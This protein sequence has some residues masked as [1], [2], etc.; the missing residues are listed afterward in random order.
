M[1]QLVNQTT[2]YAV[3]QSPG[4]GSEQAWSQASGFAHTQVTN[5][6]KRAAI[7]V[8]LLWNDAPGFRDQEHNQ[9]NQAE[10]H[11]LWKPAPHVKSH[12]WLGWMDA[13]WGLPGSLNAETAATN[14]T[15]A[16]GESYDA[17]VQRERTWLAWSRE[18]SEANQK[19]GIWAYGQISNKH[20]PFGTSP[21]FNGVKDESEQFLSLRWWNAR[22]KAWGDR[23]KITVDQSVIARY[24]SLDLLERDN[25]YAENSLRY[26]IDS[27]TASHWASV[28]SRLEWDDHW[29]LDVQLAIEHMHRRSEGERRIYADSTGEY[30][31]SYRVLDPLPF[32]QLAYQWNPEWRLFAQYGNGGSHPTSFELVD[33]EGFQPYELQPEEAN[34]IEL[35]TR[36]NHTA[37]SGRWQ[38]TLQAFH[39][40]V[41]Q[42]IAQV[43]G[44]ADGVYMDNIDGLQMT[45]VESSLQW[46]Q[47]FQDDWFASAILW[48]NWNRQSFTPYADVLPGTPQASGGSNGSVQWRHWTLA[49]SHQWIGRIKLHNFLDDWSENHHRLNAQI[50]WSTRHHSVQ[51]GVRNVL[52]QAY[53]N[54]VQ[55]NAFGGRYY[56]PAPGRSIW[57]SWRWSFTE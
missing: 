19:S 56:N 15:A 44:P 2:G 36:W 13:E 48:G 51:F 34:S 24:E 33:P 26:A 5:P 21:F 14:P 18:T 27:R 42:A 3:F 12:V 6:L 41:A 16:P 46:S 25:A 17:M 40:R 23:G 55:T 32:I 7:H 10:M 50:R 31:E 45:G 11:A 37:G 30:A 49:W 22:S 39:Q 57:V 38:G 1:D 47:A 8:N 28:G 43:P 9:R 54:W 53:S 29:Q 52:N 35:G 4:W 20:N